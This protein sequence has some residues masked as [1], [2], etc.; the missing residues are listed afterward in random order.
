MN[1]QYSPK[2]NAYFLTN[3]QTVEMKIHKKL[4]K[5]DKELITSFNEVPFEDGDVLYIKQWKKQ[6]KRMKVND[7]WVEDKDVIEKWIKDYI[8]L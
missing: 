2:F 4:N 1:T 6:P 8:K 7:E 5:R 3:G